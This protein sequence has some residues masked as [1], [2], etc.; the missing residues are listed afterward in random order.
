MD[1]GE[2]IRQIAAAGFVL[3]GAER[4]T[5]TEMSALYI[6]RAVIKVSDGA[7]LALL[8][9]LAGTMSPDDY[10]GVFP[11]FVAREAEG[12]RNNVPYELEYLG[13]RNLEQAIFGGCSPNCVRGLVEQTCEAMSIMSRY[14][15]GA[16]KESGVD[17]EVVSAIHNNLESCGLR[18][19]TSLS[20]GQ[21]VRTLCHR[22]LSVVNVM[23]AGNSVKLIDPRPLV[24]GSNEQ[25]PCLYGSVAMDCAALLVSLTRKHEELVRA[26]RAGIWCSVSALDSYV[27]LCIERGLFDRTFFL[28]CLAAYYS[29]YAACRCAYCLDP[30]RKW[31]WDL[32]VERTTETLA[33]LGPV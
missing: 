10:H 6:V 2:L 1:N 8:R 30:D 25:R 5:G 9:G 33:S 12:D 29:S 32:M 20:G 3:A 27:S 16:A 26:G 4:K 28:L 14:S 22:D 21:F 31:L 13:E 11:R 19:E 7:D 17:S 24:P 23:V 18:L 15:I